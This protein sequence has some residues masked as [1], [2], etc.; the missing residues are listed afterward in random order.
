MRIFNLTHLS[1]FLNFHLGSESRSGLEALVSYI[2]STLPGIRLRER[3]LSLSDLSHQT[4]IDYLGDH[5]SLH[6]LYVFLFLRFTGLL[7]E[8]I[9]QLFRTS[10]IENLSLT[11]T[12]LDED[13]LNIGRSG[14]LSS[15]QY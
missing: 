14:V 13:G 5:G 2:D 15:E 11:N 7:N 4:I 8:R 9:L 10:E 1:D 3:L 12:L 6:W